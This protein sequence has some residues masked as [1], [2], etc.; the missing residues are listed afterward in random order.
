M[1]NVKHCDNARVICP[2]LASK[3][4]RLLVPDTFINHAI[5]EHR[6]AFLG[7]RTKDEAAKLEVIAI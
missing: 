7:G 4:R 5:W 3:I 1:I 6:I 2:A